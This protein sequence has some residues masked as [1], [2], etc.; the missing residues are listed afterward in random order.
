MVSR[1]S[2]P[3]PASAQPGPI[4]PDMPQTLALF[5]ALTRR[6]GVTNPGPVDEPKVQA[7]L[8]RVSSMVNERAGD[9]FFV[10]AFMIF[11]VI[12]SAPFGKGSTQMG[13][14]LTFAFLHRNGILIAPPDDGEI[15]GLGF[16]IQDGNVFV[17]EIEMWLR[18]C[19]RRA[20]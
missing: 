3:P 12:R 7:I 2:A 19:A 9:I 17:A 20:F 1:P 11:E 18:Q 8:N 4:S 14:V 16:A 5:E 10:S 15:T 6:L 13:I